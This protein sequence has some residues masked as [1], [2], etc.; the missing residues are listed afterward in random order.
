M[1]AA[2]IFGVFALGIL[3]IFLMAQPAWASPAEEA[4]QALSTA[5]DK[6][7]N[8]IKN[9]GWSNPAERAELRKGVEN[10]VYRIFDFDEFSARTVGPRWKSFS[11]EEKKRFSNAFAHLLFNTYLNKITGYN[12][13][14]VEYMGETVQ[15][16]P[17]RVE[18]KTQI[19]M[20]DG[21]KT[22]VA[23][24]MLPRDGGWRVYDVVI[25]NMSLVKNYRT[26]FNDI[27]RSASP[28][29][30]I[31]RVEKRAQ[32]VQAEGGQK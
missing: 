9:P 18:V 26:Q 22:P 23:Y 30:L 28:D 29:E 8:E 20:K 16:N 11:P 1:K 27:L 31:G 19:T 24:R 25:E 4:R 10:E 6:I 13:E 12:G 2:R 14:Q 5:I 7:L 21:K 32:E 15:S 3:T 17:P